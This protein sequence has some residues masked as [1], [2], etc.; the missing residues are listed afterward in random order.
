[1]KKWLLLAAILSPQAFAAAPCTPDTAPGELCEV[2]IDQLRP[3]QA[4]IGQLQVD[5]EQKKLA[6]KS[7]KKLEKYAVKKEIP[8]V[9][10]P[11]GEYWLV[12]RHH[13]TRTLWQL[14][15]KK[16]T[17][18]VIAHLQDKATFWPQMEKNHWVW[19]KNEKG[20]SITPEQL[21]KRIADLPDYP[22]RSLAG[23]LQDEGYFDKKKQVYFVEFAWASWLGEKMGWQS[24]NA[25]NLKERLNQAKTLAC[26]P[27]A[28][29]LPGYPGEKCLGSAM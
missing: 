7:A 15:V 16:T 3:T 26:E 22:Y 5:E 21:P 14:G 28:K 23:Q 11:Q 18:K 6:D 13:L 20:Q 8:V 27:D 17:V 24:V 19:L 29:T 2:A 10:S 25:G 4:G 12:D 1:M 9:I